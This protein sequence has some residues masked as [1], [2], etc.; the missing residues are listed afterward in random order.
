MT[1][2]AYYRYWGKASKQ[3]TEGETSAKQYHL[4]PYHCLDVA[5]VG[6]LLLDPSKSLCKKISKQLDVE[7]Q[8]LR[9]CFRFCLN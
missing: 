6:W 8:W 5:A 4:L 3:A 1:S 9:E 7:P 2:D